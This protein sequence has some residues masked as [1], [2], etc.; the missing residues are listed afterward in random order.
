MN[1]K[2]IYTLCLAWVTA[3]TLTSC[4]GGEETTDLSSY[5]DMAITAFSV[6]SVKRTLHKTS[7]KGEDSTYVTTVNSSLP[8]FSIDQYQQKIYNLEPLPSGTDLTKVVVS[9]TSKSSGTI[10][11]KSLTSDSLFYYSST[12]SLDFS[13]PRE[14][15]VY[16]LNGSGYRAYIVSMNVSTTDDNTMQWQQMPAGTQMPVTPTAGWA[17]RINATGDGIEASNDQWATQT[18]ETL[19]TEASMLPQ[20][21]ANFAC[22]QLADGTAYALLVG[23]NDSQEKDD[24][25]WRKV[26]TEGMASSWVFMPLSYENPYYLPK[27]QYYWLLPYT[28]YSVLA[29]AAD[30]TIYQSRDQGITWKTSNKLQSP[31]NSIAQAATDGK[32]GIWLQDTSGAIW[33]GL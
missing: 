17:F 32:G 12:D 18:V 25:V 21:N 3:L 20:T 8:V 30:G 26:I 31:V 28:D 13:Q 4:L 9:I 10:C 6:S 14:L 33:K 1:K 11:L 19:D 16:A 23:D 15:R 27:G 2:Y 7:S 5:D 24:V 29:V 22:W